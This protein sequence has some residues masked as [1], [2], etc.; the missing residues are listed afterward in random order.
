MGV[1]GIGGPMVT[2]GGLA[3]LSGTL[4]YYARAYDLTSGKEL[5]ESRLPAGG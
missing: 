5:W 1:P 2:G 4:D 3:F